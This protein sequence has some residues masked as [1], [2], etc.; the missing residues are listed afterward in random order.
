MSDHWETC[1][2]TTYDFVHSLMDE[3]KYILVDNLIGLYLHG[4]LAMGGFNPAN[5]DIDLLGV[6]RVPLANE[7]VLKLKKLLLK[8]SNQPFPI[9]ISFLNKKQLREWQHPSQFDFHFSEFWRNDFENQSKLGAVLIVGILAYETVKKG[10][11]HIINPPES[12]SWFWLNISVLGV[13]AILES[14][15]LLKAMRE[16]TR[17]MAGG[18]IKGFK[19]VTES[20]KNMGDAKPATKLVFLED[21]VATGGA[22]I[23][24]LSIVIG[25]YTPFHEAEGYASVLIGLMLFYVVGRVFLDNAAGVLG[26]S[27][28]KMEKKIGELVFAETHV[29]DIQELMVIK[30]GEELHVE[31]KVEFDPDMSIAKAADVLDDI[32]KK[33]LN[34]KGVTEVII[35]SDKDDKVRSW[36]NSGEGT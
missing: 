17:D 12:G 8:K 30:E 23:A 13:A 33:I 11:H 27:D 21:M 3:I 36:N 35:E 18:D 14:V 16:I 20:F 32:E 10:I 24:I 5:S 28:E 2:P 9:E 4:S 19:V 31:L 26:V 1:Q 22:V 7:D 34:E 25:T 6:T 29:K 15:V